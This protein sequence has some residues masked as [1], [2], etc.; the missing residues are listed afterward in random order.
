MAAGVVR[1]DSF[2]ARS[3]T[4]ELAATG[5]YNLAD[6][7]LDARVA[8]RGPVTAGVAQRPEL[9]ILLRGPALTPQRSVDVSAL[10]GWLALRSV[11]QQ[12]RRIEAIEQGRQGDGALQTPPNEAVA[13]PNVQPRNEPLPPPVEVGPAPGARPRAPQRVEGAPQ[14]PAETQANPFPKP[15]GSPPPPGP[16]ITPIF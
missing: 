14:R 10:T 8:L 6:S 5:S 2:A 16:R 12:T 9:A 15:I 13:T 4:A 1:I 11:D 3:D 7:G